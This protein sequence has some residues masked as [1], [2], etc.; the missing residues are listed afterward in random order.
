MTTLEH[1]LRD[2]LRAADWANPS[3]A[4][5][6][7]MLRR[8]H[9]ARVRRR[10]IGTG[11]AVLAAATVAGVLVNQLPGGHRPAT[12]VAAAGE[13]CDGLIVAN[14]G[15]GTDGKDIRNL[16]VGLTQDSPGTRCS[17]RPADVAATVIFEGQR[18]DVTQLPPVRDGQ[19]LELTPGRDLSVQ[20]VWDNWC[21]DPAKAAQVSLAFPGGKVVTTDPFQPSPGCRDSTAPSTIRVFQLSLPDVST[22][23]P[24]SPGPVESSRVCPDRPAN[25]PPG[26]PWKPGTECLRESYR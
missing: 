25:E 18:L 13:S 8:V 23:N 9:R 2:T 14:L 7:H 21:G 24:P 22:A 10:R 1:E 19:P 17:V 6:D 20:L 4:L 5:T 11:L 12:T 26:S 3:P 15:A 16:A